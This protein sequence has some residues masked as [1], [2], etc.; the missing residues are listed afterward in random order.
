MFHAF[1]GV[2]RTVLCLQEGCWTLGSGKYQSRVVLS[3]MW[4]FDFKFK[5]I[6]LS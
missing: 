4:L 3:G 6:I 5:L 1:D 2:P